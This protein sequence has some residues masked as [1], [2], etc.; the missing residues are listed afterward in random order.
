MNNKRYINILTIHKEPNYGACLQ[1]YA[2]YRKIEELGG[3]PRMINLS[4]DYRY[5]KYSLLNRILIPI[6]KWLKGYQHCYDIAE[7]FSKKQCPNQVGNFYTM[8]G[9]KSYPWKSEDAFIIGSDQV[10]NPSITGSLARSYTFSFLNDDVTKIYSY[11]ASFGHISDKEKVA[12][13]LY[14]NDLSRFKKI[15][16]REQFGKD[17][18]AQYNIQS[19]VVVDPTLLLDSYN[20]LL[21]KSPECRNEILFLSLSDTKDMNNFVDE[22][23]RQS[24]APVRKLF[25]YLQP[26]RTTNKKFVKIEDWLYSIA[27]SGLVITDSFHATVF[28]I[29]FERP[30]LVFISAKSKEARI[31][32]LLISLGISVDRI[33]RPGEEIDMNALSPIDF[34]KVKEKLKD[35]RKKSEE[36]LKDI[37]IAIES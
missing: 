8:E 24:Q 17:Y 11:A 4:I 32:N 19:T 31:S 29:I 30:F 35:L 26:D 6:N 14:I 25:G 9:M 27:S 18:L 22:V 10:W 37:V 36:F 1:A 28:S 12:E 33:I 34:L 21:S 2:L 3:H 15:G 13:V 20:E 5:H 7:K 16:V 23:S